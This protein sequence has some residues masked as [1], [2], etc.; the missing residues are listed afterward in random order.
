M[1]EHEQSDNVI[2]VLSPP[3]GMCIEVCKAEIE[4]NANIYEVVVEIH[5]II[6]VININLHIVFGF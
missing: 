4:S 2:S 6:F 3:V 1:K 5:L